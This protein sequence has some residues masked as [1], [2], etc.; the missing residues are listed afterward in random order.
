MK[1][2]S[3]HLLQLLLGA[4]I[5][6][7]LW[8]AGYLLIRSEVLPSPWSVYVHMAHL[9]DSDLLTH[10]FV[11]LQR[12]GWGILIATVLS[13]ILSLSMLLYPRVGRILSTFIYFTYPIP[14]LALLPVVML[15]GG[16]GETTKVVMIVLII[17]FQL[18]VSMRDALLAIPQEHF[19][20]TRSLGA[21][22]FA[23]LRHLLLPAALPVALSALRIAIG[24]AISV[25]FV[26]ETYGTTQGLGYYISDAWVRINYLDM[27]AGISL[28]SL[29]GVGLFIFID[30]IE[31]LLCPWQSIGKES[32]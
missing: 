25:L 24:T 22:T 27:Y 26:T 4:L 15:L 30:L 19:A 21:S 29:M 17:L 11:S 23:L 3:R 13:S 9:K 18:A 1:S 12:I 6:H 16:L 31:A 28:L 14:K 5:L 32:T 20:V 7:I 10:T 8:L 2:F